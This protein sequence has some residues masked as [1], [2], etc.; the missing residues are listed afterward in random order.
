LRPFVRIVNVL[1][2]GVSAPCVGQHAFVLGAGPS[3]PVGDLGDGRKIGAHGIGAVH[4]GA[5]R[6]V[7]LRIDVSY[8]YFWADEL[9]PGVNEDAQAAIRST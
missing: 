6:T 9:G 3:I 2:L 7:S 8:S 4:F 5:T 1:L